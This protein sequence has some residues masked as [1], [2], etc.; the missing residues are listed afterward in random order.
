MTIAEQSKNSNLPPTPKKPSQFW[1]KKLTPSLLLASLLGT[2]LDLYFTGKE[3]YSFPMRPF[4][5]IFSIHIF[6]TLVGIPLMVAMFLFICTKLTRTKRFLFI[7]LLSLAMSVFE[8][9]AEPFGYF[10]H[11]DVW[12]H[13]YSFFGYFVFLTIIYRFYNW[14]KRV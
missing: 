14:T 2:Y 13:Y 1:S 5:E 10:V 7:L 4:P 6:F 9:I 12:K 11:A 3:Y 8:K